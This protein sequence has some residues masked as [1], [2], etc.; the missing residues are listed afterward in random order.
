MEI[1]REL[2]RIFI[3]VSVTPFSFFL[4][5]KLSFSLLA[6]VFLSHKTQRICLLS[7]ANRMKLFHLTDGAV[8][9]QYQ[10]FDLTLDDHAAVEDYLG[11]M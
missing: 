7:G 3:S 2:A 6:I 4:L 10:D 11:L 1:T 8:I 5:Q 9:Y